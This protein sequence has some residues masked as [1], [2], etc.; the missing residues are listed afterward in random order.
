MRLALVVFLL[1]LAGA[2]AYLYRDYRQFAATRGPFGYQQV[3]D[4]DAGDQQNY[5]AGC[6]ENEQRL[7]NP[8]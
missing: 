3:G 6:E 4:V 5:A 8:A 7:A 2:G 1:A